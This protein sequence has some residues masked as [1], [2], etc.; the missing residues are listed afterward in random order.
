MTGTNQHQQPVQHALDA[1]DHAM[2]QAQDAQ[3]KLQ[4][5]IKESNP[6]AIQSA[7]AALVQADH[8]V[9]QAQKQLAEFANDQFGQQIKQTF[10]QLNQA[11]QDIEASQEKFHTPKQ[12]R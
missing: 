12:V 3:H 2:L 11:A 6:H 9:T 10:E 5:A 4:V 7:Q 8:Q 1:A